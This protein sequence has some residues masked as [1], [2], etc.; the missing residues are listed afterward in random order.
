M[1]EIVKRYK[2]FHMGRENWHF[3]ETEFYIGSDIGVGE[4]VANRYTFPNFVW[5]YVLRI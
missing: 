3:Q 4:I 2:N 5:V 1:R